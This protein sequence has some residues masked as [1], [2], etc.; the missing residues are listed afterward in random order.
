MIEISNYHIRNFCA[1]D[2]GDTVVL[3]GGSDSQKKVTKFN[4][5]GKPAFLP[6]LKT[7][8]M[9]HTCGTFTKEDGE[10]VIQGSN[11]VFIIFNL[12]CLVLHG[13]RWHGPQLEGHWHYR[14]PKEGRRHLLADSSKLALCQTCS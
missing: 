14:D 7:E 11:N 4:I 5:E 2:D 8:R 10:T 13:D 9:Y 12:P 1:I 3:T 6:D